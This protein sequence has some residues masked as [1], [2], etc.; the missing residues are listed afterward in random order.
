MY[1][2]IV[3]CHIAC[4]HTKAGDLALTATAQQLDY[5]HKV[6]GVQTSSASRLHGV[7]GSVHCR[8]KNS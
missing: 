3:L 4:Q 1:E 5:V 7:V 8:F 2:K 6:K